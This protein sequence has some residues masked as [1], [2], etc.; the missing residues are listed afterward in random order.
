MRE[1]SKNLCMREGDNI[2]LQNAG[3]SAK[4]GRLDRSVTGLVNS[5]TKCSLMGKLNISAISLSWNKVT[6]LS[7]KFTVSLWFIS[8][9]KSAFTACQH[10]FRSSRPEVLNKKGVARNFTKFTGKHLCQ[11]IFFNKVANLRPA[12]LLNM[13]LWHKCFPVNFMKFIRT[14]FLQNTSG[15]LLLFLLL[16]RLLIFIFAKYSLL[17]FLKGLTHFR[18]MVHFYTLQFADVLRG[19]RRA[20]LVENGLPQKVLVS[21][22]LC[23]ALIYF[24]FIGACLFKMIKKKCIVNVD[25]LCCKVII[26]QFLMGFNWTFKSCGKK[27]C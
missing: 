19:Y 24:S 26:Q 7:I 4:S 12:T 14:P 1:T 18:P 22:L 2:S 25:T 20:I 13:R 16:S 6:P 23:L 17:V 10:F 27:Q 3:V 11:S 21:K 15:R 5:S 9:E 8:S